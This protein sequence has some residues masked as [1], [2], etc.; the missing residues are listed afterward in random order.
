M[1]DSLS[2]RS[3]P[4]VKAVPPAS[5]IAARATRA[6]IHAPTTA[7]RR[8]EHQCARVDKTMTF[9]AVEQGLIRVVRRR[10]GNVNPAW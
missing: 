5:A 2:G 6:T 10:P 4:S 1:A 7:N 8:R 9:Q 3:A